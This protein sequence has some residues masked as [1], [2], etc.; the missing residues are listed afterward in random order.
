MF[1]ELNKINFKPKPFQCYTAKE[2]WTNKHTSKEMLKYHLNENIDISSRKIEFI[3]KSIY[4]IMKHFRLCEKSD[5]LDI[6]CGPGLYA[7]RFAERKISVTGIDFSNNSIEYA[8]KFA[9][10]NKLNINYINQNYLNY[11]TNKKFDLIIMIMCD[12][13][14]LSPT[15]RKLLLAK[16]K[17]LLKPKGKILLD[18]YTLNFYETKNE[19]SNYIKNYLNNFWSPKTYYC[20]INT[21]KYDF[22]KVTLDKYTIIEKTKK[23][24]VY[25]WLQ[26]YS[27]ESLKKEFLNNGFK[28]LKYYANVAGEKFD[29][30]S[31]EMAIVASIL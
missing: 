4:W 29:Q 2:L 27:K 7:C 1:K 19:N 6:G 8:E 5:I 13:C 12:F 14:A 11:T 26:Y 28:I 17:L 31:N 30:Q 10:K 23:R 3:N 24:I 15:Q 21:F 18:V 22:E 25:N 16:F 9:K 20:F